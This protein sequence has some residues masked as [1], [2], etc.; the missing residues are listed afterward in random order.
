MQYGIFLQS[1][2]PPERPLGESIA[3][4]VECIQ[5]GDELG[6]AEAWVGEHLTAAWEPIAA[7]DLV[8]ARAIER[9]ERIALCAGA[10]VLPFYHPAALAMRVMQLDHM[11]PGRFICG[12]AA[13]GVPTDQPLLNMDAT[14]GESRE[15]MRESLD[16][17]LKI[18][19]EGT[20]GSWE[21]DG[22]FWTVK[23][24]EPFGE[25]RPHLKPHTRPH[26]RL[27][28]AGL[29]PSSPTLR[30]AGERGYVPMSLTFNSQYLTSHWQAYEEGA[31]A[32]GHQVS[33]RGWRVVRD[34]FV[35]DTDAE[36]RDWVRNGNQARHWVESNFDVLRAFDWIKYLKHDQSVPDDAVDVDYLIDHLWLVGSPETV[37]RKLI[38]EYEQLGGFG[39]LLVNKYDYEGSEKEFR[40]SL[41]LLMTEVAPAFAASGVDEFA[42]DLPS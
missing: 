6:F 3:E 30:F 1:S 22:K 11:L 18:W 25:L 9:T 33:R 32:G 20:A 38:Q 16:I 15:R 27:A 8:L 21:Y 26:P 37:T 41:T 34:V 29:S 23:N 14:T 7:Q 24:P 28:L 10:Y 17:M 5:W 31:Q 35:A 2:H 12:I 42:G 40:R 39:T 13:G 36:A 19:T 4:D